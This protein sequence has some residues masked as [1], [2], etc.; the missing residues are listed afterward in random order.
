[1]SVLHSRIVNE[2][3]LASPAHHPAGTAGTPMT[4]P[5]QMVTYAANQVLYGT[6]HPLVTTDG[7]TVPAY[8]DVT[9]PAVVP[10]GRA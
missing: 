8:A 10:A 6:V 9:Y 1:V 5:V 4:M 7:A 3:Y 2:D